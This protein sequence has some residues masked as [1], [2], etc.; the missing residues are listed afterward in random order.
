MA[1]E[2][3]EAF[4]NFGI[5]T[6]G[7]IPNDILLNQQPDGTFGEVDLI[8]AEAGDVSTLPTEA[9][10][11]TGS[12][13]AFFD[14]PRAA[15][16][17][18]AQKANI[19]TEQR[20]I[21]KNNRVINELIQLNGMDSEHG[22]QQKLCEVQADLVAIRDI[23]KTQGLTTEDQIQDK[24]RLLLREYELL[25]LSNL[26]DQQVCCLDRQNHFSNFL[27]NNSNK[28]KIFTAIVHKVFG[29]GSKKKAKIEATAS[30]K[31]L[32]E[33]VENKSA[34]KKSTVFNGG[35]P[36]NDSKLIQLIANFK[37]NPKRYT[38]ENVSNEDISLA[39]NNADRA[40]VKL[41]ARRI[42]NIDENT[43]LTN[44]KM[45]QRLIELA[46]ERQMRVTNMGLKRLQISR[47]IDI[48][49]TIKRYRDFSIN[50]PNVIR[51]NINGKIYEI[52]EDSKAADLNKAYNA[53]K[54]FELV[55]ILSN[56]PEKNIPI[57]DLKGLPSGET[58]ENEL[59][60]EQA[61]YV[62]SL[63]G[64]AIKM[65]KENAIKFAKN[66]SNQDLVQNYN[67]KHFNAEGK[68]NLVDDEFVSVLMSE[69]V[70]MTEEEA[71]EFAKNNPD[72]VEQFNSSK[73][74]KEEN[75]ENHLK[76]KEQKANANVI[77]NQTEKEFN[78]IS[79]ESDRLRKERDAKGDMVMTLHEESL[80]KQYEEI[81]NER[82]R[83]NYIVGRRLDPYT[84]GRGESNIAEPEVEE[85]QPAINQDAIS[86]EL[87]SLNRR[88]DP[89]TYGRCESNI[90]EPEV[91][92]IQPAINQDAM[93][94]EVAERK[95]ARE[96]KIV[97]EL[98]S[99][100]P[101]LKEDDTEMFDR[102]VEL[103]ATRDMLDNAEHSKVA[104]ANH[105]EESS[106]TR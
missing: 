95:A 64:S 93:A 15:A 84:Y 52:H 54:G 33:K 32:K 56:E 57:V 45:E 35:S 13:Q 70:M 39:Q 27:I 100:N 86:D 41:N 42:A 83:A 97:D 104:N 91:E 4:K 69:N 60:E 26:I 1:N 105:V 30:F 36:L 67:E 103:R 101:T 73:V 17:R 22:L 31:E 79:Y 87:T 29:R 85:I 65:N 43:P 24:Q 5:I 44:L 48:Q 14:G 74:K 58:E 50:E 28:P 34:D 63:M 2:V 16:L 98:A 53:A 55:N 51:C 88:L 46:Y 7:E 106:R 6:N 40:C 77:L 82:D 23:E 81:K 71:K 72:L 49:E 99:E 19:I 10:V 59:T 66:P 80:N 76:T 8:E 47:G 11:V 18:D 25:S 89:Y 38:K 37:L 21:A 102:L 96:R 68:T 90:A 12:R 78:D 94:Q 9:L 3:R 92:E 20:K 75:I 61:R 62:E